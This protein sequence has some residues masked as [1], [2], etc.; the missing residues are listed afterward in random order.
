VL[1]LTGPWM[2]RSLVEYTRGLFESI[3][4]LIG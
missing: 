2:I 3:P 4:G 1:A